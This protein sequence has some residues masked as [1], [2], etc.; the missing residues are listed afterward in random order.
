MP[1]QLTNRYMPSIRLTLSKTVETRKELDDY[2]RANFGENQERN[3]DLILEAHPDTLKALSLSEDSRVYGVRI[4]S[5]DKIPSA[6]KVK[7]VEGEEVK[8]QA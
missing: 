5:N 7:E 3:R 4:V 1:A 8:E 2:V 6:E